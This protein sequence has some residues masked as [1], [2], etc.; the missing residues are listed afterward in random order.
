V[1]VGYGLGED[2]L[3][4][5]ALELS[6]GHRL[7]LRGRVDRVDLCPGDRPGET[8]LV[9]IDYKS[10]ARKLDPTR[11]HHGLELQLPAYLNAL[12]SVGSGRPEFGCGRLVAAGA[13]YVNL[14]GEVRTAASRGQAD[15][16]RVLGYQHSGRFRADALHRF[17]NRDVSKGDQFRYWRRK[18]G[19]FAERGNEA[20]SAEAMGALLRQNEAFLR[21]HAEA[22]FA[23][24]A[25]VWPYRQGQRTAC[26][27]C[28]CRPICRFDPWSQPYHVLAPPPKPTRRA[29]G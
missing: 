15:T 10:S 23:G 16:N 29:A 17:D 13:F 14:R 2:S 11:L 19:N 26:E 3:P 22:I 6:G 20:V 25:R 12:V 27:L 1:E 24:D 28:P 5:W 7:V 8:L 18:D 21:R 4:G 9:V